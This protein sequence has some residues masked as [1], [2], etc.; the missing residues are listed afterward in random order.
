M[1]VFLLRLLWG[2]PLLAALTAV[3]CEPGRPPV[4]EVEGVVLLNGQPLANAEVEF[5]PEL[6]RFG[7]EMNSRGVT[8]EKGRF[9]LV[10]AYQAQSGAAVGKHKVLVG[11]APAR[12]D[13]R[14]M[15]GAS[16]EKYTRY[17]QSLRNR[18]IPP[19]YGS[20]SKTPLVIE[21]TPDKKEYE[22][23]LVRKAPQIGD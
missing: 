5:V 7:A 23:K 18:P 1:R 21:V 8:D 17:V 9:K 16:Q 6:S 13:M 2:L 11:E 20:I 12:E 22:L 14:G 3:G 10:C 19:E 4:T 15:D